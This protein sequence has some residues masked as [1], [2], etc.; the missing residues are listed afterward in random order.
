MANFDPS[1]MGC[2]I[3]A[4]GKSTGTKH[5]IAGKTHGHGSNGARLN[6]QEK[7]PAIQETHSGE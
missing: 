6:H 3:H 1:A 4:V 5:E 7:G 2:T